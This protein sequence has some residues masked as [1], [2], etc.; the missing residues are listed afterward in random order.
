[1][2]N[3]VALVILLGVGIAIGLSN[4]P[5]EFLTFFSRVAGVL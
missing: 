5:P 1:M 4:L 3:G 2:T